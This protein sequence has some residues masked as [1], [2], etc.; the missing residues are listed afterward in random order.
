MK[1]RILGTII[2][3]VYFVFSSFGGIVHAA[4]TKNACANHQINHSSYEDKQLSDVHQHGLPCDTEKNQQPCDSCCCN[5]SHSAINFDVSALTTTDLSRDIFHSLNEISK[6]FYI[7]D[8]SR[9]PR[10]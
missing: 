7:L 6:N 2:T 3:I 5:H 9:P 1:H 8:I 4:E 10:L